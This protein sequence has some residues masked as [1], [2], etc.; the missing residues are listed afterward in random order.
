MA[1]R[2][3]AIIGL[4]KKIF[5]GGKSHTEQHEEE[6]KHMVV[7]KIKVVEMIVPESQESEV[8]IEKTEIVTTIVEELPETSA[9]TPEMKEKIQPLM[10]TPKSTPAEKV[11]EVIPEI[12]SETKTAKVSV[13]ETASVE[14]AEKKT[15]VSKEP[16]TKKVPEKATAPKEESVKTKKNIRKTTEKKV[17]KEIPEKIKPVKTKVEPVKKTDSE[18]KKKTEKTKAA[19]V[20]KGKNAKAKAPSK[21]EQKL[22]LYHADIKKYLGS[23]DDAFLEVIVKNLG[24][25]IYRKDAESVACTDPKEL[26]TVKNNFLVKKLK[27]PKEDKEAL[28]K[29]V[30]EV[31]EKLKGVRTKYRATFYYMLA[32]NLKKESMLS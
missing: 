31:C 8:V 5:P 9:P 3:L 13:P 23:V 2:D 20:Q 14:T 10:E 32:K 1:W 29:A 26:E 6:A 17:K 27:M 30:A 21:K 22:K 28:D 12:K 25:S 24:P 18:N 19:P 7:E 15:E 11:K 4:M 16:E